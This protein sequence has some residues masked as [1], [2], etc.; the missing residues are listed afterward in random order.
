MASDPSHRLRSYSNT[1]FPELDLLDEFC[2]DIAAC[3]ESLRHLNDIINRWDES[4]PM[5][6]LVS[7]S[8]IRAYTVHRL[9]SIANTKPASEMTNLDY[10]IE[11]CRLAALLYIRLVFQ[12]DSPLCG[13][14]RILKDEAISYIK[15]GE[16]NGMGVAGARKQPISLIWALFICGIASLNNKE[17]ECFA[18]VLAK[19]IRA[20]GI[21]TWPEMEHRLNQICWLA[22]LQTP[23][24]WSLW[25]RIM[26]IQQECW[27]NQVRLIASNRDRNGPIYWCFLLRRRLTC[28]RIKTSLSGDNL[29]E[30]WPLPGDLSK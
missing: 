15:Q 5:A 22:K 26:T 14:S 16:A 2:G 23:R 4:Q 11:I 6:E 10:Q 1:I 9:Q 27:A 25:N 21:E 12:H 24:C 28:R 17:Q 18:Q 20:V 8:E 3:F 19:A 29:E 13:R 30:T 7:F